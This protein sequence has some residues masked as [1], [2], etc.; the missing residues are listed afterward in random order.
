MVQNQEYICSEHNWREKDQQHDDNC[1]LYRGGLSPHG[2]CAQ[3]YLIRRAWEQSQQTA[4]KQVSPTIKLRYM[5]P[6]TDL[7]DDHVTSSPGDRQHLLVGNVLLLARA[8][9]RE[10]ILRLAPTKGQTFLG[11]RSRHFALLRLLQLIDVY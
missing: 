11:L 2:K 10:S 1:E 8:R 4:N 7:P 9:R 5:I 6:I 3:V